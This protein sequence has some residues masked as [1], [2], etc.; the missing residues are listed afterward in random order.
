MQLIL[1]YFGSHLEKVKGHVM[2]FHSINIEGKKRVVNS[3]HDYGS[4]KAHKP[5][6]IIGKS[7]DGV[8]EAIRHAY[9]PIHGIMWHPERNYPFHR[10]DQSLIH[11]LF[12]TK[13]SALKN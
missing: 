4:F 13:L 2:P 5:L 3:Y 12:S 7:D 11:E 6:Q 1:S 8:I 10:S 9:L